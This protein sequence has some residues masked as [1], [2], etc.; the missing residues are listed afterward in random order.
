MENL[1]LIEEYETGFSLMKDYFNDGA[2]YQSQAVLAWLRG[3]LF[4]INDLCRSREIEGC[5]VTCVRYDNRREQGYI[6]SLWVAG[7]DKSIHYAFYEHRNCDSICIV[8]FE[9]PVDLDE[10]FE[11]PIAEDVWDNMDDKWDL[12]MSFT[13]GDIIKA[14]DWIIDDMYETLSTLFPKKKNM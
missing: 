2:C 5:D 9:K 14:A 10:G 11:Q 4:R 12:S 8:R 1:E 7:L 13:W 3:H 6:V